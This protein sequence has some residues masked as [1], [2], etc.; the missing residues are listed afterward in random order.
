MQIKTSYEILLILVAII[1]T[2]S[3]AC[4][5]PSGPTQAS[6]NQVSPIQSSPP[7]ATQA[8]QPQTTSELVTVA[9]SQND[10]SQVTHV[11]VSTI[12]AHWSSGAEDDGITV[13]PALKDVTNQIVIWSGVQLPVDIEIYST[14][15]DANF[16]QI[17][18]RLVYKGTGTI[19]NWQDG[20]MFMGGGIQVP[21]ASMNVP[22]GE[23]F[24]WTYVTVHMPDGKTYS[25]KDEFTALT[26]S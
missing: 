4:I 26:P 20:N 25:A 12:K 16:N 17:K 10:L 14:K 8:S 18:D 23:S 21:F 1:L 6:S 22:K 3:A 11:D 2:I 24:G 9:Q 13:H 19:T 15:F 5:S 7:Q